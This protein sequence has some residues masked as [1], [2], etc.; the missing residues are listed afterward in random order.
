MKSIEKK[1]IKT[2]LVII[3]IMI[4]IVTAV[5]IWRKYYANTRQVN[6]NNSSQNSTKP[7]NSL[8][9]KEDTQQTSST[10][11]T[12]STSTPTPKQPTLTKSS[13]NNAPVP[14]GSNINFI[15]TAEPGV[16]CIVVL[17]ANGK[18]IV[19]GPNKVLDD[20]R[21]QFFT[22]FYWVSLKGSYTV[23]AEV[24]NPQGGATSSNKQA[25]EVQ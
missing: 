25:L 23:Y 15:C 24:K 11:N 10:N 4:L 18:Q 7:S 16:E 13:G 12:Q 9:G 3:A 5:L 17:D 1:Q 20:G 14:S 2:T 6:S 21:G 8:T 19:L 22:S